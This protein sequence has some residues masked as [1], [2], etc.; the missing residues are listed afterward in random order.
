MINYE[1]H[2]PSS[3]NAFVASPAMWVLERI[4]GIKQPVGAKAHRGVAVE[5]GVTL[6]LMNPDAPLE[7]CVDV[8]LTRYDTLTA[9]SADNNREKY[10]EGISE[11]IRQALDKLRAYGVPSRTQ[12]KVEWKPEG[13]KYPFV[14]FLDYEFA[15]KGAIIDLKTTEKMPSQIGFG[16]ARQVSLYVAA[17]GGN[18]KGLLTYVT[19]KKVATYELEN[20]REHLAALYQI[21]WRIENFLALSDD[22]QFFLGIV[23]PDLDHYFW[24]GAAARQVAYERFGI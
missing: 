10:R 7:A 14:G 23:A 13:L 18:H 20:A 2:S 24:N 6:G 11:M 19:P 16:H 15:D 22:P 9:M 5:D 17:A 4:I 1:R 8:A 12:A 3:C 21:A